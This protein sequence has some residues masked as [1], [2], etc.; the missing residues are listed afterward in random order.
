MV[1]ASAF[2]YHDILERNTLS[3]QIHIEAIRSGATTYSPT[4]RAAAG[5]DMTA[6]GADTT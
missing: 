1:Y 4:P 3:G 2:G 5:R 6:R